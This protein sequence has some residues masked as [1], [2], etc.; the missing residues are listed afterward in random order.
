MACHRSVQNRHLS[1]HPDTPSAWRSSAEQDYLHPTDKRVC[2]RTGYVVYRLQCAD[3]PL[4][5]T[6][7]NFWYGG[8]SPIL[9]N[10]V[11]SQ[12]NEAVLNH[13]GATSQP[14]TVYQS[15]CGFD[16][17]TTLLLPG[18]CT[19]PSHP[20]PSLDALHC[21]LGMQQEASRQRT[22]L[23]FQCLH[24]RRVTPCGLTG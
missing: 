4:I 14:Q 3:K 5:D 9:A 8:N 21:L 17:D 19:A 20:Q 24:C 12:H 22:L 10:A 15:E 1:K 2:V 23:C 18:D 6:A 7:G 13:N 16:H 11:R